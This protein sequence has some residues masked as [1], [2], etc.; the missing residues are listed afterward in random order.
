MQI[1][2]KAKEFS[3]CLIQNFFKTFFTNKRR[4]KRKEEINKLPNLVSQ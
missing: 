1:K 2:N 3:Y 4:K